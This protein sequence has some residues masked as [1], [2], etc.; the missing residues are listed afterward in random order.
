MPVRRQDF[1]LR[2]GPSQRLQE[3]RVAFPAE[4]R[5]VSQRLDLIADQAW[6]ILT[7]PLKVLQ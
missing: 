4:P 1:S 3:G 6:L 5:L 7:P 2:R